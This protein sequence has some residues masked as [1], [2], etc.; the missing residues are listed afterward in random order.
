M[1]ILVFFG[2]ERFFENKVLV[3]RVKYK[4]YVLLIMVLSVIKIVS[5]VF[6]DVL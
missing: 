2:V 1:W 4:V 5:L 6:V 3:L